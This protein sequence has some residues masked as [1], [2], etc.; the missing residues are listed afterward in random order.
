MQGQQLSVRMFLPWRA[1]VRL[2]STDQV[3]L[4]LNAHLAASSR[5]LSVLLLLV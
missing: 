2:D 3:G 4:V 5:S 1:G